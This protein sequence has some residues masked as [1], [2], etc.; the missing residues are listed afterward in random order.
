MEQARMPKGNYKKKIRVPF[1]K[2]SIG[3][4][5]IK[6]VS[7]CLSN[8]WLTS[9][10]LVQKFETAFANGIGKGV[11]AVA[12]NS[13][14]AGL[15]LALEALG[16]TK[17]DEVIL[18]VNTFTATAEVV[19]YLG[20]KPIFV[21]IDYNSM[22]ISV[23]KIEEKIT[24][25]TKALVPVHFAGRAA[26][27]DQ[28]I[29]IANRYKLKVVEDA[30]HALPATYKGTPIGGLKSDATVFSFYASKTMTTGE[31]GMIVT[32]HNHVANRCR[33]L[34]LHGI[35]KASF[36]RRYDERNSWHYDV[37]APGYKYNMTDIAAAIG[38]A[39]LKKN[40]KLFD[41]RRN[42]ATI[43]QKMLQELPVLLPEEPH[44]KDQM[45]WHLFVVRLTN[46]DQSYRNELIRALAS[47]GIICSVH[48]I[49]LH[50]MTFWREY[51]NLKPADFP[52]AQQNFQNC[53][54]LPLF[55]DMT[56][57]QIEHVVASLR[58]YV[59]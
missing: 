54:S 26:D 58:R 20:A 42:C 1:F 19:C 50:L 22:N 8:G 12:V 18:P 13:A 41:Q 30:A 38:I 15:H 35:D 34:R 55:P 21:D 53:I 31:G 45:S 3:I 44:S 57:A 6:G 32:R 16:V 11:S 52:V 5:E 47:H 2:P 56:R 33:I 49:P 17:G 51:L 25:N 37:I 9:G 39:Q 43:Y 27:M 59:Y 24:K 46:D 23:S 29:R 14:T 10:E 40:Q 4:E 36:E 28:I 7:E 48:F